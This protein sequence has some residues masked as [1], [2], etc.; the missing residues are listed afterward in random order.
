[1]TLVCSRDPLPTNHWRPAGGTIG[2]PRAVTGWF[3]RWPVRHLISDAACPARC[4]AHSPGNAFINTGSVISGACRPSRIASTISGASNVRATIRPRYP[5]S[6]FSATDSSL[7]DPYRPCSS[8]RFQ[9][10]ARASAFTSAKSDSVRPSRR[11]LNGG[12]T[13][14]RRGPTTDGQASDL[15]YGAYGVGSANAKVSDLCRSV[16][17]PRHLSQAVRR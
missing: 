4:F 5:R 9:R 1:M 7:I 15:L 12:A 8:I 17:V 14:R 10:N 2:Q 13:R 3:R 11:T 16:V 6:S